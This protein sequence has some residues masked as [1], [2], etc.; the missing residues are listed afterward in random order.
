[1]SAKTDIFFVVTKNKF[2]LVIIDF[3]FVKWLVQTQPNS[4]ITETKQALNHHLH[5]FIVCLFIR[6]TIGD[7]IFYL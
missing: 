7:C 6:A 5:Q 1:M 3:F 2:N 4:P